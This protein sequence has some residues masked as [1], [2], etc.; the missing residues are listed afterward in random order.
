M[1]PGDALVSTGRT[2]SQGLG[3]TEERDR[4]LGP[5]DAPAAPVVMGNGAHMGRGK[6]PVG[7]ATTA[8]LEELGRNMAEAVAR[9]EFERARQFTEEAIRLRAGEALTSDDEVL[10]SIRAPG[11]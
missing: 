8:T 6:L 5:P 7:E 10:G 9:G 11:E 3:I 1:P 4:A 2:E